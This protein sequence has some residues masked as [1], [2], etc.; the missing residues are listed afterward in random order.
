MS[1]CSC[2]SYLCL[3]CVVFVIQNNVSHINGTGMDFVEDM[4]T[5]VAFHLLFR[6]RLK[7]R[8]LTARGGLK[9]HR[10]GVPIYSIADR[11]EKNSFES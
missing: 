1:F 9:Q 7:N 6:S 5:G 2:H 4:E 8:L 11:S 10:L 3:H